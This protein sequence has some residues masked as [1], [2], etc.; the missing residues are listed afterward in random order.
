MS[1]E[2]SERVSLFRSQLQ[3]RRTL[4]ILE[5][6][7]VS[8][9]VKSL[10]EIRSMLRVLMRSESVSVLREIA[11]KSVDQKLSVVEFFVNAFALV[12]DVESCLALKYE[13]L[14]LRD[15]KHVNHQWLRVSYEEWLTFAEDSLDNGFHSIAA[16]GFE[17]ALLSSQPTNIDNFFAEAEVIER[18]KKLRDM[19]RALAASHSVQAQAAEY[20]N[21]KANQQTSKRELHSSDSSHLASSMFRSGIK[22]RNMQQLRKSRSLPKNING[23]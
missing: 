23:S 4:R 9:D 19:A 20:L 5:S 6:V 15:L 8:K 3:N 1:E 13:A 2:I 18:I 17:N 21:R 7:L 14:V 10:L 12:R 16:K 11:E 22:K